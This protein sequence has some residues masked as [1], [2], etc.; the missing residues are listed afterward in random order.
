MSNHLHPVAQWTQ[1]GVVLP[2]R[3]RLECMGMLGI[4]FVVTMTGR[5]LQNMVKANNV[6]YPVIRGTLPHNEELSFLKRH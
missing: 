5:H 2:P 6:K 1:P 4:L 3:G